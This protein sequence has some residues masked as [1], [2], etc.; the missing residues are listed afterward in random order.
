[1]DKNYTV[2][3]PLKNR[4]QQI[5]NKYN[6]KENLLHSRFSFPGPSHRNQYIL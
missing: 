5:Y 1:M 4:L 6:K 2:V 3:H